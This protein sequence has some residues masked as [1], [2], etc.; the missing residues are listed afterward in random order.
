[1]TSFLPLKLLIVEQQYN[2]YDVEEEINGS[3]KQLVL[4][5]QTAATY[6]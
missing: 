2:V 1:M 5:M 6:I 4:Y 3:I